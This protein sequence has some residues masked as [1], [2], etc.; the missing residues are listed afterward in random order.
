MYLTTEEEKIYNGEYGKTLAQCMQILAA[1]G[2]IYDADRLIQIKS[3]QVAGV[4]YKTI[5]DAGLEWISG[6][7]GSVVVPSIL[8]PAGM[9]L[10][11]WKKMGIDRA[12]AEKQLFTEISLYWCKVLEFCKPS[13]FEFGLKCI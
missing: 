10:K 12:F 8:N 7:H 9:D 4:S 3:V 13:N 2:D 11:N 1:L 5:G 6:L